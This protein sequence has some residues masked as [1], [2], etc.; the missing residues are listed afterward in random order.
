MILQLE[1]ALLL[2]NLTKMNVGQICI[3]EATTKH[4][5]KIIP[6]TLKI[7]TIS[8]KKGAIATI[9]KIKLTERGD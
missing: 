9:E 2:K 4:L 1:L 6:C 8:I 7:P 5:E 3:N